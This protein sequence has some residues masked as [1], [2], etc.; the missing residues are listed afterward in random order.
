MTALVLSSLALLFAYPIYIAVL[1]GRRTSAAAFLDADAALPPWT[2][3][4]A[5]AGIALG[6]HLLRG[7]ERKPNFLMLDEEHSA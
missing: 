7:Q 4:F 1:A 3:V 6:G 5:G 2:L